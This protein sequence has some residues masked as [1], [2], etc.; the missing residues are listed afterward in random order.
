MNL[1]EEKINKIKMNMTIK[2]AAWMEKISMGELPKRKHLAIL[3]SLLPQQEKRN[4]E[5]EQYTTPGDLASKWIHGIYNS[6]ENGFSNLNIIDI[7]CGN[8][9]LGLG[10]ALMGA[11]KLTLIDSD[12]EAIKVAKK[13]HL[14]LSENVNLDTEIDFINSHIGKDSIKIPNNSLI[15]SNPPW[16]TQK[17]KSDR[18][19]LDSIFNSN[20]EEIHI[21][22]TNKNS[23]LIPFAK[24]HGW[25]AIKM[26]E[27]DFMIPALYQHHK[28][29]NSTTEIICWKFFKP[30]KGEV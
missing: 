23:H 22:H 27:A 2:K 6:R 17:H 1:L 18:P 26:I 28:Q 11:K 24:E 5:L 15:I 16:G 30:T 20:T 9:V 3:L 7:G 25:D 4:L 12:K 13:S 21:M 29:K 8:G 14:M 10:C 19:I